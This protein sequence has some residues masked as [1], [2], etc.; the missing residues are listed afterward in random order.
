[1]PHC[2]FL[3]EMRLVLLLWLLLLLQCCCCRC[4][5]WY[6]FYVCEERVFFFLK[7]NCYNQHSIHT[8][9][10]VFLYYVCINVYLPRLWISATAV[11]LIVGWLLVVASLLPNHIK[12]Q[13]LFLVLLRKKKKPWEKIDSFFLF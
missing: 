7:N 6:I 10:S 13:K 3:L 9:S 2:W 4:C 11:A 12:R 1:M 8:K 5:C